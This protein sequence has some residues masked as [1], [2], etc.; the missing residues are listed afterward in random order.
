MEIIET[1]KYQNG[2]L[3]AHHS[4]SAFRTCLIKA[5]H[6]RLMWLCVSAIRASARLSRTKTLPSATSAHAT[7]SSTSETYLHLLSPPFVLSVH[8]ATASATSTTA[9]AATAAS[10]PHT[11]ATTGAGRGA[12]TCVSPDHVSDSSDGSCNSGRN[13]GR[14]RRSLLCCFIRNLD[15][16]PYLA[17][18]GAGSTASAAINVDLCLI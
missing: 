1:I 11:T 3:Y 14:N 18:V 8:S 4:C 17:D 9:T 13:C 2:R 12:A 16:R 15:D 7:P 5:R 10:A 6:T